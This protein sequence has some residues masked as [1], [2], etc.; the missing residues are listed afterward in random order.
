M[1]VI[2]P[3]TYQDILELEQIEQRSFFTPHW[4]SANFLA[5]EC[6]VAEVEG[7]IA[8]F[9]VSRAVFQGTS[10]MPCEREILNVAVDPLYRRLGIATALLRT[11]LG[12][13]GKYYLEVRESNAGARKL[14]EK[15]GFKELGRREEYYSSPME[16]AIVM[17]LK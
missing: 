4:N 13:G 2:R 7:K 10:D 11:E 15:L 17:G 3:A 12:H 8:G 14:Y 1:P 6:I 16:T 9:L 5:Y